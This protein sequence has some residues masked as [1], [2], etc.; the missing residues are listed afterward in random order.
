M[1]VV[2]DRAALS[3]GEVMFSTYG[4][5]AEPAGGIVDRGRN[6]GSCARQRVAVDEHDLLVRPQTGVHRR[7]TSASCDSPLK[8]VDGG[9]VLGADRACRP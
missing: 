1:A 7:R 2:G 8:A 9:D 4:T 5:V 6:A 3:S